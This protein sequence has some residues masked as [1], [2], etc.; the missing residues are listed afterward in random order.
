MH[1][2]ARAHEQIFSLR[3]ESSSILI[4][5][6]SEM[7]ARGSAPRSVNLENDTPI[8]VI[9][10]SEAVVDRLKGLH[11]RGLYFFSTAVEKTE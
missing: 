1:R 2:R 10:V 6:I 4:A 3:N 5:T 11:T 7:G 9:D 8:S